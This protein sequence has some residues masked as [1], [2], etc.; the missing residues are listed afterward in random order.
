MRGEDAGEM[1][2]AQASDP[3]QDWN[4]QVPVEVPSDEGGRNRNRGAALVVGGFEPS[5]QD[6]VV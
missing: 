1:R 2:A 6:V 4:A 5:S 3:G